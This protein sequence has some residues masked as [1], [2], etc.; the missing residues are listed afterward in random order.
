MRIIITAISIIYLSFSLATL[1]NTGKEKQIALA[2][3]EGPVPGVTES[4]LQQLDALQIKATFFP[5][6]MQ[7]EQFPEQTRAIINA[8]H[9]LGNHGYSHINLAELPLS[10]AKEEIKK[11][12]KLLQS[13]GY[14]ERPM[15]M[16]PFG[17]ISVE[18]SDLLEEQ[19]FQLAEW[20][21][22]PRLH[23]DMS[24]PESIADYVAENATDGSV[25][26]FHPMYEHSEQIIEALPLIST[27]LH[28]QG[29]RFVTLA[30][31]AESEKIE[32]L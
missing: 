10:S 21:L 28:Q 4:L 22:E 18:L 17:N 16:P 24:E 20:D 1:A 32:N 2:F 6:G 26:M 8:G 31:I 7:M 14:Q 3:G 5:V 23:V 11:T 25:V 27:Q 9:Q 19:E 15:I 30:Q 13:H 29:F 12:C